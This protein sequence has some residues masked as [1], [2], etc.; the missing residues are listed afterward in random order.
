MP[1]RC[2]RYAGV[3]TEQTSSQLGWWCGCWLWWL[4]LSTP[5]HAEDTTPVT[6]QQIKLSD[7]IP[8]GRVPIDYFGIEADDAIRL[9][10]RRIELSQVTLEADDQ[11]GFLLSL[12]RHLNIPVES[13]LLVFSKTARN[14]DLIS[15]RTPRAVF[16]N[17][18]VSVAWIPTARELEIT[19][20]DPIKGA[21]FYTL[22]QP[23]R[24]QAKQPAKP[25]E[26]RFSRNS[27]CLACHAGRSS[28]DVPG[29][30]VR[31]FQTDGSGKPS[32]GYSQV[33]HQLEYPKRWGGWYVTG[34]PQSFA[35]RGNLIG[36]EENERA[37]EQPTLRTALADLKSLKL[38]AEYPAPGSDVVA[39]LV[40][41]HQVHGLNLLIRVGMEARL[42][43]RSDA[44]D[45]LIRYLVFADE[46]KLEV[47][48]DEITSNSVYR[49]GFQALGKSE[50]RLLNPQ[51]GKRPS[52]VPPRTLRRFDLQSRVFRYR[53]SYLVEHRLF[54]SLPTEC[55][56]RLVQR[57]LDGLR[58]DEPPEEFQHLPVEE[59][60]AIVEIVT[61]AIPAFAEGNKPQ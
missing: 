31:A 49:R 25:G 54:E 45:Q 50:G 61:T 43:R 9:L 16:F 33:T 41:N 14:P 28:L 23:L 36:S 40:Y 3:K 5:I 44:E 37:K 53:L 26:A 29:W 35:H 55:R 58:A 10:Q 18:E 4:A 59:R 24:D 19:A 47:P 8:F 21:T 51:Q 15:P 57:I 46:P 56:S 42:D 27:Q 60:R 2:S 6:V 30:L 22:S 12:L 7:A 38:N 39:H 34:A 52:T 1:H 11:H 32:E 17:D 13:Q 20:L 48:L